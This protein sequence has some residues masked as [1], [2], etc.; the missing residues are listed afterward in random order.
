LKKSGIIV[1]V[2]LLLF[3]LQLP[4]QVL[5]QNI[6]ELDSIPL[7]LRIDDAIQLFESGESGEAL[8]LFR[9]ILEESP[10]NPES[11]MWIGLILD[12]EN[13]YE[14][15][16]KHLELALEHKKQLAV[17]ED[18]YNILYKL[19][20]VNLKIGNLDLYENY[21]V[22]VIQES[23]EG[24][25]SENLKK[26]MLNVLKNRGYDKFIELYRPSSR[27]SLNAYGFLGKYNFEKE[28]WELAIENFAQITGSI[29]STVIEE[30]KNN[31]S[32]YTFLVNESTDESLE[33]ILNIAN[34]TNRLNL[35]IEENRFYE[36][37]YYL[38]KSLVSAG[39]DKSGKYILE[40][41]YIRPE[42]GKW[43]TL[44]NPIY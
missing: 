39:Y 42:A 1:I 13:E 18:Q 32:E 25:Y 15:A 37:F 10:G 3:I 24:Y 12:K 21:L 35:Y 38:G 30:I 4:I 2:L 14:L 7:W 41:L 9:K 28:N 8:Y 23:N 34:K 6:S 31:N 22:K 33:N 26:T 43:G 16:V 44:S 11:E 20:E 36:Y 19:S 40:K 29:L 27:I 17:L 5:G